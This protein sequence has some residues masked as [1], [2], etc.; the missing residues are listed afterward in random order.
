[1]NECEQIHPLLRGYLAETVS[2]RDRRLVA[3]HLNLCA[4]A[5]KELDRLRSGPAKSAG[6][7]P[8][9]SAPPQGQAA[10]SP[11]PVT[12]S[13]EPPREPWDLKILR[14]M[15]KTPKPAAKPT[16]DISPKKS[17]SV[18][19][20][21]RPEAGSG[22]SHSPLKPIL[23]I[24]VFFGALILLTHFIQNA[25]QNNAVKG[26]KRWLSKNG[27]HILGD[28]SS[29]DFVLDLTNLSHWDGS[30]A[31][32]AVSYQGLI[33]DADHYKIYW[34]LLQPGA[35]QPP[36]DFGKNAL[37]VVL[38]GP[39]VPAGTRVKFKRAE[40]YTDKTILWYDETGPA[41]GEMTAAAVN[42]P[43]ALQLV[44][45]PSQQPVLIQKIQ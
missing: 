42:R 45:K 30:A 37:A 32:V 25:G 34:N 44:P 33:Q 27:V 29:L 4:S 11:P 21:S 20:S 24:L 16:A 7:A 22:L 38:L 41:P 3:R 26:A 23:K 10:S 13:V 35:V 39:K 8:A 2:A 1:M 15:F 28:T 17:R 36:V 14:W 19:T 43:W 5:R 40:N 31:P 18:K 12:S 6:T 9:S